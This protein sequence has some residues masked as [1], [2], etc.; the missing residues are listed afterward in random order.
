M[1]G[2]LGVLIEKLDSRLLAACLCAGWLARWL[3][4][5]LAG[6]LAGCLAAAAA[7]AGCRLLAAG[8]WRLACTPIAPWRVYWLLFVHDGVNYCTTGHVT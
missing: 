8:C 7:V 4:G 6:W 3:A 1:R 2:L 5:A